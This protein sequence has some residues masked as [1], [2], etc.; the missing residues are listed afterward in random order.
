M[1]RQDGG[2]YGLRPSYAVSILF[3]AFPKA[4]VMNGLRPKTEL[5]EVGQALDKLQRLGLKPSRLWCFAFQ[6][7]PVAAGNWTVEE[8]GKILGAEKFLILTAKKPLGVTARG[9]LVL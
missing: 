8:E 3:L 4:K 2:E 1:I 9:Q 7:F 5:H 6:C